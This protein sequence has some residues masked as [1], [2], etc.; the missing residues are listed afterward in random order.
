MDVVLTQEQ[1]FDTVDDQVGFGEALPAV[2]FDVGGG[3]K[4]ARP[5]IV[6]DQVVDPPDPGIR[7]QNFLTDQGSQFCRRLAADQQGGCLPDD[8]HSR[9]GDQQ[10][11]DQA[12]RAVYID[13][14]EGVKKSCD[15]DAACR[16]NVGHAVPGSRHKDGGDQ[17]SPL[18]AVEE[19]LDQ[20]DQDG[21]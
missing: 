7:R 12:G 15:Q 14:E 18:I 19:I 3:K 6:Y 17:F 10:A 1:A 2:Q 20:L 16:V 5:V 13:V 4:T 9:P 21:E 11:D 8:V